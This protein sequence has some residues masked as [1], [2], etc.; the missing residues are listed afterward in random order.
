MEANESGKNEEENR[1]VTGIKLLFHSLF[2]FFV[3][4][5]VGYATTE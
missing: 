4:V 1:Y 3:A 5:E 2:L